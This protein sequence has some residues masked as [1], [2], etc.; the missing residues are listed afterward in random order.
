MNK[1]LIKI[2]SKI[3]QECN[4]RQVTHLAD[5]LWAYQCS[6]KSTTRCSP[7]SLVYGTKV[8]SPMEFMTPFLKVLQ[9]QKKEKEKEVFAAERKKPKNAAEDIG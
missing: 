7:F 5:A 4:G 9:M 8:V 1:T 3:S 2:I 6:P